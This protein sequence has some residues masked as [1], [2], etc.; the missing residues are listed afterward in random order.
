MKY[1]LTYL[2]SN[3]MVQDWVKLPTYEERKK[4]NCKQKLIITSKIWEIKKTSTI[5]L[6][7]KNDN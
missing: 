5:K 3:Y 6:G 1:P 4:W 7:E 2:A